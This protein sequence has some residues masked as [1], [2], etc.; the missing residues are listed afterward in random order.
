MGLIDG[1]KSLQ[2]N[3][4]RRRRLKLPHPIQISEAAMEQGAKSGTLKQEGLLPLD[5]GSGSV[6]LEIEIIVDINYRYTRGLD[7]GV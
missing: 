6:G 7:S 1:V 2:Q 5:K 4:L 3:H